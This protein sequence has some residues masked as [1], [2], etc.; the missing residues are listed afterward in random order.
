MDNI[1]LEELGDP[2][3]VLERIVWKPG[4]ADVGQVYRDFTLPQVRLSAAPPGP[5]GRGTELISSGFKTEGRG[6]SRGPTIGGA[7]HTSCGQA[8]ENTK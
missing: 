6:S 2:G 1:A 3:G 5:G 7:R 4:L 8:K